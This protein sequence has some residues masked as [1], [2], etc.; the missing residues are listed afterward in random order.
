MADDYHHEVRTEVLNKVAR[1]AKVLQQEEIDEY[2]MNKWARLKKVE[3]ARTGGGRPKKTK[4]EIL[5]QMSKIRGDKIDT[6]KEIEA[7]INKRWTD[8]LDEITSAGKTLDADLEIIK[9]ATKD[10]VA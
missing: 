9:L 10:E 2:E 6:V 7:G 1:D 8:V 5:E 3:A 4:S